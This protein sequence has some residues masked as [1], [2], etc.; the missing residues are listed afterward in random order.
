MDTKVI[1][2]IWWSLVIRG[3]LALIFGILAFAYTGQTMLALMYVFG[4]FAVLSGVASLAMAV[5]AEEAHQRW[6]MLTI[7]GVVSIVAG[8]IA[9]AWPGLTALAAVIIVAI[10][11]I[12]T[13]TMEITFV[14]AAPVSVPHPWL[15]GLRCSSASC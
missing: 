15:M 7:S 4:A 8:V 6:A 2:R 12:A 11:A 5:R 10:W 1:S 9:F 3:A 13:G 14:L